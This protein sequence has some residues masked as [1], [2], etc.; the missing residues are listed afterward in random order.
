MGGF[1]IKREGFLYLSVSQSEEGVDFNLVKGQ[2]KSISGRGNCMCKGPLWQV[3]AGKEEREGCLCFVG[4][5]ETGRGHVVRKGES[6][7][8]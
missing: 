3:R 4:R 2:G 7:S 6:I 8:F 5:L 1:E